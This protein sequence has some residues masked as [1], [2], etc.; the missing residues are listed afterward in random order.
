M[1]SVATALSGCKILSSLNDFILSG[2]LEELED[3]RLPRLDAGTSPFRSD[4]QYSFTFFTYCFAKYS[5]NQENLVLSKGAQSQDLSVHIGYCGY[6]VY[7]AP[8]LQAGQAGKNSKNFHAFF[9]SGRILP[10]T[11]F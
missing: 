2:V 11:M 8:E 1:S 10:G 5:E 3:I 6:W 4:P 7:L 9:I